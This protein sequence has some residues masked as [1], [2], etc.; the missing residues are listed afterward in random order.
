MV[1]KTF[2][3]LNVE[4]MAT[5]MDYP[6]LIPYSLTLSRLNSVI[7]TPIISGQNSRVSKVDF[8]INPVN[9]HPRLAPAASSQ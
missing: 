4:V 7:E 8:P 5:P 2:H 3:P 6:G 9:H 1:R